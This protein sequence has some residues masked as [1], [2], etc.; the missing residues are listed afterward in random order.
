[1]HVEKT[2]VCNGEDVWR[3]LSQSSILV[4]VYVVRGVDGQHIVRVDCNQNGACVCLK[5]KIVIS[6]HTW[7]QNCQ[8]HVLLFIYF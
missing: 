6:Q 4:H 1:M 3:E 8:M 7:K 5:T 2:V